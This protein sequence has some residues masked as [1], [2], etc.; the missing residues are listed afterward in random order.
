MNILVCDDDKAIVDAIGIYLENEGY[1]ILKSFNGEEAIEVIRD[2]EVHLIIMDIMMPKMDGIRATMKIREENNIP[3]IMLSAKS[4]DSDK[5]LGLNLGADDYITKPFN[6][7]ELIARVKSQLRRYTTFGSL[8]TRSNVYQTGGLMIDD[9][10]RTVTIDGK[11]VHL[12]PVQYKIL[13][14]LT[15]NA[16]RVFSIEEIYEKIWNEKSFSPEN[17]VTVH[18]RKI[19]EKIEINPKEPK[20]LKV[21]WGVGYKVEKI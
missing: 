7:L 5:I 11:E 14:L 15:A 20:Y 18:I 10:R 16:G 1:K 19:R 3:L 13:K 12:T 17:T 8:E 9:E 4:E 21:V 6:P 2:H